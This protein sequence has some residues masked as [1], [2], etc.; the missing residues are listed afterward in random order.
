VSNTKNARATSP[1]RFSRQRIVLN[2]VGPNLAALTANGDLFLRG[3]GVC[4][5]RRGLLALAFVDLVVLVSTH[6]RLSLELADTLAEGA[7]DLRELADTKDDY[8]DNQNDTELRN[9]DRP[10]GRTSKLLNDSV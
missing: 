6:A 7:A 10:H 1:G 8:D 9:S 5:Q 2:L 4:R 3:G